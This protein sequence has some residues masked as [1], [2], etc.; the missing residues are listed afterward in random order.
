MASTAFLDSLVAASHS[1]TSFSLPQQTVGRTTR[2][3][4]VCRFWHCANCIRSKTTRR[5]PAHRS[6]NSFLLSHLQ[7]RQICSKWKAAKQQPILLCRPESP[8]SA[9]TKV[10]EQTV[11]RVTNL[12]PVYSLDV[13]RKNIEARAGKVLNGF[14][15]SPEVGRQ[16]FHQNV[17]PQ[18]FQ[19]SY[20]FGKMLRPS[21]GQI[22]TI[23]RREDDVS[24][25]PLR[26]GLC[27]SNA[28]RTACTSTSL[29]RNC[30]VCVSECAWEC[31]A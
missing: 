2:F 27:Q 17:R 16:A 21:I 12:E 30:L 24:H 1:P 6:G 9:G 28:F 11:L 22:V 3:Y 26:D 14:Q 10:K 19:C 5:T 8:L 4:N 13:M 29:F 18:R 20:S 25:A 23:H 15:V 31:L 7:T